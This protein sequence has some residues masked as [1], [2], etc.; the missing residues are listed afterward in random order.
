[1]RGKIYATLFAAT[2]HRCAVIALRR[3]RAC[4]N[5]LQNAC[6]LSSQTTSIE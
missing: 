2:T 3:D 5:D 1:M 4:L 6:I